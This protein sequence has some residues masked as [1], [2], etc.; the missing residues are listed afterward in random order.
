MNSL[1]PP[2]PI[3]VLDENFVKKLEKGEICLKKGENP[4]KRIEFSDFPPHFA[5]PR[6]YFPKTQNLAGLV[7]YENRTDYNF[8]RISDQNGKMRA[9]FKYPFPSF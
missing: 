5:H 8:Y 9:I 3:L 2:Y 1:A 6:E 7:T 4:W